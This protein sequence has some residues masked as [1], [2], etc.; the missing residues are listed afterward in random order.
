MCLINRILAYIISNAMKEESALIYF[1]SML[2]NNLNIHVLT[3]IGY[4]I[5]KLKVVQSQVPSF[6][7]GAVD[8]CMYVCM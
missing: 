1:P 3:S 2:D 7:G 6:Y 4:V 5:L 8:V